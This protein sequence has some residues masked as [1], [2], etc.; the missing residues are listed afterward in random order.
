[1]LARLRV[2]ASS[3]QRMDEATDLSPDLLSLRL[4]YW[5]LKYMFCS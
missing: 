4:L 3:R 5:T 1:M 2:P